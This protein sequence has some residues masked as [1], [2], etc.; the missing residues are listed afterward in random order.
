M[1]V[2]E[3]S[4]WSGKLSLAFDC[5]QGKTVL[6]RQE[7]SL[8]LAFQKPLYPEGPGHCHGI[9][10]H[11]PGGIANDDEL[12][13]VV[14][15]QDNAQ[16]LLTS[17]G[18]MKIYRS[19]VQASQLVEIQ[20]A[21]GAYLE[22]L[23]QETIL[24]NGARYRQ[25]TRIDLA[26]K[27]RWLGW[28]IIRF[29]RTAAGERFT[30][31]HWQSA[32]EVWRGEE[33]LWIDRQQLQGGSPLLDS[34]FGLRGEAVVASLIWI[35]QA[36]PRELLEDCR[37][38]WQS[39]NWQGEAGVSRLPDGLVARYRGPSTAEARSWFTVI[40]NHLRQHALQRPACLPRV[41]NT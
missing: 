2:G 9:I 17:P 7:A 12:H 11:P 32:T 20:V 41:W 13:V 34:E 8:P 28:D 16:V 22:W 39:Q 35:G 24:F 38:W 18:A 33:P 1:G 31:G 29:G 3:L 40:W 6:R 36:L 25:H 26:A 30:E 37:Q 19:A 27:A 5:L 10:L 23:P 4:S 14:D 21:D 15:L